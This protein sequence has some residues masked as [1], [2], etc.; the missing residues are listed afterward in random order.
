MSGVLVEVDAD[1]GV[2]LAGP[3]D[4]EQGPAWAGVAVEAVAADFGLPVGAPERDAL[5]EVLTAFATARLDSPLRFLR[6][7]SLADPPLV[8]RVDVV[9]HDPAAPDPL[10]TH[11]EDLAW[12]DHAATVSDVDATA[13]LRRSVRLYVDDGVLAVVRH[14]RRVLDG[15]VDV[16]LTCSGVDLLS[17][18][19][20]MA[21]LDALARGV[22]VSVQD[23]A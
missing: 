13:G 2:W 22:H 16:V 18:G 4:P 3:S 5:H 17:A 19:L 12:Y 6:L 10:L 8:V 1:P 9:P 7:R 23:D 21:D 14:H 15:T 11:D 20:G